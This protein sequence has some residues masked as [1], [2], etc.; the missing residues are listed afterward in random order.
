MTGAAGL[1]KKWASAGNNTS[2]PSMFHRNMN[3]SSK[4]MSAWN[5][6]GLATQVITPTASV[7]PVSITTLPV[8]SSAR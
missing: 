1:S 6:I 7:T 3:A 5:L 8:N 2:A 4:P